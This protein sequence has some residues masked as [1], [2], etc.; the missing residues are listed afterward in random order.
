MPSFL[1]MIPH[2]LLTIIFAGMAVLLFAW[3]DR[4]V[5]GDDPNPKS[6][7]YGRVALYAALS[8]AVGF[9]TETHALLTL[10]AMALIWI[11]YRSLPWKVGGSMTP[12]T[13]AERLATLARHSL[14]ALGLV[15][16]HLAAGASPLAPEVRPIAVLP[17]IAFAAF[18]TSLSINFAKA[19]DGAKFEHVVAD[20]NA[21]VEKS[22]GMAFGLAM[23]VAGV[24]A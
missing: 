14:P 11:V 16:L 7:G 8:A 23:L 15:A 3:A 17:F 19:A 12:R 20:A 9:L 10:G 13:S 18:S 22:R 1:G 21:K 24:L 2:A 5:G 6:T 4:K